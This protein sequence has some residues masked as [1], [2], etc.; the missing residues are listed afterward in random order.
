[1][2]RRTWVLLGVVL[3]VGVVALLA[4]G[5]YHLFFITEDHTDYR[6]AQP[7]ADEVLSDDRLEDKKPAFDPNLVDRR[8]LEGWSFNQSAAVI[9]LDVPMIR[10]DSEAELLTLYPSY[11]A[12]AAVSQKHG[13]TLL[14]SVNLLDGKAKQFDD[15]LYAALDQAYYR[16]L[17]GKLHGHV[18]LVERLYEKV[19]KDSPAAPFLAA[20]LEL[21]G[22]QVAVA[23]TA[24]KDALV[25]ELLAREVAS[26]P[27]G[28]YT[29]NETLAACFRFL[30]FFQ[31]QFGADELAVPLAL[32]QA[33]AQDEA[34]LADYRKAVDFYAKLTNPYSCLS[35]ADLVGQKPADASSFAALCKEKHVPHAAVALFPLSTA[36]ETVLFEKLFPTGLPENAD[37]MREL[38]R[39]I[40]SGEIDLKPGPNS[41]WYEYQV[42]ALETFLLPEKGEER[43]KL[44]LTKAYKKRML[45][46][47][48]ALVTKRRETH[49]RQME[50]ATMAFHPPAKVSPRLRVEPCPSY[51]LRTARA[52]AFLAD[53]LEA[54]VG[55]ETLRAL[56][57]LK[58]G[59]ERRPDL[60]GELHDMRDLFYG[61]YLVSADDIGLKPAF[62]EKEPV[63]VEKCYGR[64]TA[65]LP[66]ALEDE[67]LAA[68]TRVS[69]PIFVDPGRGVTRLW[70]TLG[71][72]LAK[73]DASYARPPQIKLAPEA[74]KKDPQDRQPLGHRAGN[75]PGAKNDWQPVESHT[76]AESHYL[77]PVDQFAEVELT[78]SRVLTREE[79]RAVCDREKT[80]EAIVAALT[81]PTGGA[82]GGAPLSAWGMFVLVVALGLV[83]LAVLAYLVGRKLK[84]A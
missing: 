79:L 1:M 49:L 6:P 25:R 67:D 13:R 50:F 16:G 80:K 71:V 52:Y 37:L 76:L 74:L 41:G 83:G 7:P 61:L 69:V 27:I 5:V 42:Y 73:L 18:Q 63:D 54:A 44:L 11:A 55:Q 21:A 24:Q 77:I 12:A 64:A 82:S 45:E 39:R 58:Q 34:L 72:R 20:G 47:F 68:D 17:D 36:R 32:A 48:Q 4:V 22:V 14:P 43:S 10:P 38:V 46:A 26:K 65:W 9:R 81:Q 75:Q 78:Q 15:G 35:V 60:L 53:F 8:P 29:W 40:R 56:H 30:R 19:G 33:L 70:A 28:F 31:R 59:G 84:T 57:G 62:L 23:D 51:Y 2:K 3:G 66:K